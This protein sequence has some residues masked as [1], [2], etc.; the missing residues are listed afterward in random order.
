MSLLHTRHILNAAPNLSS[1]EQNSGAALPWALQILTV[2]HI[3]TFKLINL[4]QQGRLSQS[5]AELPEMAIWLIM[6]AGLLWD[7]PHPLPRICLSGMGLQ[8]GCDT[9][10]T[11]VLGI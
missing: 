11:W 10:I 7:S 8:A 1:P 2:P 9:V 6:V 4:N 5:N 3:N